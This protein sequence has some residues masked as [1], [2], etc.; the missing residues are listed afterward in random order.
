[1]TKKPF[2]VFGLVFVLMVVLIPFWA[3]HKSGDPEAR[4]A[5][6]E[7]R[8]EV[9]Q[10][11]KKGQALFDT[12]CGTCHTLYAAGTDGDFGPNLDQQ[13]APAG[14]A[15]GPGA[16]DT[17]AGIKTRVLNAINKGYDDDTYPGRMPAGIV[18]GPEA[19]SIAEFV[20]Q[21]AGRG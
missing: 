1:M 18:V 2:I 12:N 7:G 20:S 4:S 19:D 11:L 16:A 15:T 14:T 5:H 10:D 21:T 8:M 9:P 6:G 17:M 13:L 3:F